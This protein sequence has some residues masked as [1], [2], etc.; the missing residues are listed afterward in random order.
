MIRLSVLSFLLLVLAGCGTPS[1]DSDNKKSAKVHTELAGLYFQRGQYGVALEEIEQA[2]QADRNF[3][4]AF[5][6]RGL[7]HMALR[8]DEQAEVD[9][10]KGLSIDK[11]DADSHNNYG[12]FLCQR[13]R[14]KESIPH[15]MAALKDPLYR[16]PGRAFLNAGICS[17]KMGNNKDAQEFLQK[18]LT[19]QPGMPQ[20][21]LA[22][23]EMSFED[24]DYS[25]AKRYFAE[26]S[27]DS[28]NLTAEQL[29][30]AVRIFR[31]TEDR[32]AAAS[33]GLQLRKRFPDARETELMMSGR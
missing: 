23:A 24:G 28:D 18:A 16:T 17:R 25:A 7:I 27:K 14:E 31:K 5:G 10:K 30:L 12:W 21:L 1:A 8:E 15:F 13:G 2:L 20:A 4:Q 22:M 32:N 3:A 26:F 9:F 29:W 33:Y 11:N 6:V 19:T